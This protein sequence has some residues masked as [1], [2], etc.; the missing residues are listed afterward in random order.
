MVITAVD[1]ESYALSILTR[2]IRETIPEA[3]TMAFTSASDMLG[4][5][6]KGELYPEVAFLDI[7]M[8]G[9]SGL[10]LAKAMKKINAQVNIIFVT[11]YSQ[12]AID[13]VALRPSGYIMKPVTP[14]KVAAE[15]QNLRYPPQRTVHNKRIYV[16]C[17]GNFEVFADGRPMPFR[18]AKCRELLAYLIDRRG[19]ECTNEEIA[20]ILWEDGIYEHSRQKQ[21]SVIRLDLMK[22]LEAAGAEDM[23][24]REKNTMAVKTDFFDCDYYMALQGDIVAINSYGGEYMMQYSWAE[25]TTAGLGSEIHRHW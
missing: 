18:R 21:L 10:D 1:D 5:M 22:S 11:G 4:L 23:V 8:P 25:Y 17:F 13:A 6:E 14:V 12:Y 20:E 15:L 3:Q 7:S 16:Q 9:Y 2:A 19:E 24:S